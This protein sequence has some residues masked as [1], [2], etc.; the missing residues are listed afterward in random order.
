M[1]IMVKTD[2]NL[3]LFGPDRGQVLSILESR[4][5]NQA[6]L[7]LAD[8]YNLRSTPNRIDQ[9]REAGH[10]LTRGLRKSSSLTNGMSPGRNKTA[11]REYGTEARGLDLSPFYN[12]LSMRPS[13]A[14]ADALSTAPRRRH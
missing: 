6:N 13:W 4:K 11:L 7:C 10:V 12:H 14:S 3:E 5:T 2:V 8:D 1:Y 9:C